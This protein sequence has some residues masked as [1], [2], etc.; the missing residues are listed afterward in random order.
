[1]S[2]FYSENKNKSQSFI[3]GIK[4]DKCLKLERYLDC[5]MYI[6]ICIHAQLFKY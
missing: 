3:V 1:M 5:C 2:L 4:H 6:C